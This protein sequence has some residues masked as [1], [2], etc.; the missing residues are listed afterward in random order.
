MRSVPVLVAVALGA[1][2]LV[3]GCGQR[4][5]GTPAGPPLAASPGSSQSSP[6]A[7][8]AP[9]PSTV[10]GDP[11]AASC[12]SA[13]PPIA[14]IT[15]SYADNGRTLC[16][17]PGTAVQVY[18][19]GTATNEWSAIHTTNEAVL[20]PRTN[21]RLMLMVGVT[22]ASFLAAH[23]GT[24]TIRSFQQPCGPNATPGNEAAQSGVMEC[25]VII[26]FHVTVKVT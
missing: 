8:A 7:S 19:K 24:A 11:G 12:G 21:G 22:R 20:A 6:S 4:H 9:M 2:M 1:V 14:L 15:I 23:P 10:P 25:G 16:V 5:A 3:S 17:R 26:A 18:L 13:A